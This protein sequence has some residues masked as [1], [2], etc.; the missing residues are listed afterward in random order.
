MKYSTVPR[1]IDAG[2]CASHASPSARVIAVLVKAA[3]PCGLACSTATATG[4]SLRIFV[5][6]VN[7]RP[8]CGGEAGRLYSISGG[9]EDFATGAFVGSR[10]AL[11][12][13]RGG[14]ADATDLPVA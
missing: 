8:S 14:S 7:S 4:D 10:F 12:F 13:F 1:A 3:V 11:A 6:T 9:S 2:I 5:R